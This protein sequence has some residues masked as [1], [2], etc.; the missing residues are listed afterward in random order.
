MQPE[1]ILTRQRLRN[2]AKTFK[3]FNYAQ[4][5]L[6]VNFWKTNHSFENITGAKAFLENISS[7][8]IH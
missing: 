4:Y 5:A 1:E 6:D 7:T 2:D 8:D 3:N